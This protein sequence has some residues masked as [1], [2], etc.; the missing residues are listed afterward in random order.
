MIGGGGPAEGG[1]A[2]I[3][4]ES[5]VAA[6]AVGLLEC[7]AAAGLGKPVD[8]RAGEAGGVGARLLRGV[9]QGSAGLPSP[10][11]QPCRSRS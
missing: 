8:A 6:Q 4:E 7:G 3:S 2:V 5:P 9:G 1:G 10:G 11:G